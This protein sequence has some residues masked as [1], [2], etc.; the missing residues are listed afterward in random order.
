MH[1]TPSTAKEMACIINDDCARRTIIDFAE[2][3]E[4][5]GCKQ[6]IRS[7]TAH[8][9]WKC[10]FS[11]RKPKRVLFTI[12]CTESS[13]H[14]KANLFHMGQ[15]MDLVES[16]SANVLSRIKQSYNCRRCYPECVGGTEFTLH[17]TFYKKCIGCG[18]YFES[19]KPDEWSEIRMLLESESSRIY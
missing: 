16:C 10:T 14:I 12:E 3:G 5:L 8:K 17:G 9:S 15:Y 4:I 7:A 18:F 2:M 11:K 13:W 6:N 1:N 19:M